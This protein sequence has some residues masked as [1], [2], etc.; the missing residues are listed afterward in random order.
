MGNSVWT[1]IDDMQAVADA[2][3]L[4]LTAGVITV[5][6][7]PYNITTN[8]T[9]TYQADTGTWV[10]NIPKDD[11][12][13]EDESN[14]K[15][16]TVTVY[17][18]YELESL[19]SL[20]IPENESLYNLTNLKQQSNVGLRMQINDLRGQAYFGISKTVAN[21]AW[22]ISGY[23]ITLGPNGSFVKLDSVEYDGET[24]TYPNRAEANGLAG[25][26]SFILEFGVVDL[27]PADGGT[28][29]VARRIYV[30]IDE[31]EVLSWIDTDMDRTLGSYVP[32]WAQ[33]ETVVS[34]VDY[35][36]YELRSKTPN[37][38]DISE[39]NS[40]LAMF[41]STPTREILVGQAKSATNNAIRMKVKLSAPIESEVDELLINFSN[42]S[43]LGIWAG[44]DGGYNVLF[45]PDTVIV[46]PVGESD[47]AKAQ[48]VY[49]YPD[50][51]F[52]LEFG[53]YD[54]DVYKD[55]K[56]VSGYSRNVYV[57]IDGEEVLTLVHKDTERN[58]GTNLWVYSSA[59]IEAELVSLTSGRYLIRETPVVQDLLMQ[60]DFLK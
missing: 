35:I 37:V 54:Q 18:L 2:A 29:V 27:Y 43:D 25:K 19:S 8:V 55:G 40:G 20:T 38:Q 42:N 33:Y 57:K 22:A 47:T 46:Y 52:L 24:V 23:G 45:R 3:T 34:S 4:T 31:A 5:G 11:E 58:L 41:T 36:R 30:K 59:N 15:P 17:D 1:D 26:D 51:E 14:Y 13:D 53:V 49:D 28:E 32:A 39:I 10:S 48:V 6:G 21:N 12:D 50:D 16:A 9:M 60:L 7:E 56:K 44:E